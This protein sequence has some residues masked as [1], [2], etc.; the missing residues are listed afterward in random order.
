MS[1]HSHVYVV[2]SRYHFND[3]GQNYDYMII[4][5]IIIR[6]KS[7]YEQGYDYTTSVFILKQYLNLKWYHQIQFY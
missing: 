2:F 4:H 5:M 7:N 3:F 1:K 6:T